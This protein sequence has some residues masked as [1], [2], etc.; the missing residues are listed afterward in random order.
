[1]QLIGTFTAVLLLAGSVQG[2]VVINEL[3]ARNDSTLTN[4]AGFY[5]DWVELYNSGVVAINL[6]GYHL[7]DD[8]S[9]V[10]NPFYF[11]ANTILGP[12]GRLVVWCDSSSAPGEFHTG[13]SLNASGEYLGL[14]APTGLVDS[15]TFGVQIADLSIG[16]IPDGPTGVW[17]LNEPTPGS[18][19][20]AKPLGPIIGLRINEW[21]ATNS[22]PS[23]SLASPGRD[24]LEL[25][26]PSTNPVAL[27]SLVFTT[28]LPPRVPTNTARPNLSFIDALGYVQFFCVGYQKAKAG[29]ELDFKL[30]HRTGETNTLYASDRVTV[31]DQIA[32][33]GN[34]SIV[35]YPACDCSGNYWAPDISYGRL[36]DGGSNIV[37]FE[38]NETTPGAGNFKVI[39]NIVVNEVLSH[40]DPPFEDAI[41]LYNTTAE[42]VDLSNWWISNSLND[43]QKFHI[44]TN[45]MIAPGGYLVFYE[46]RGV[47]N[48]PH[49]GFNTSATGH[50]PDFTLNSAHGDN[51]Y[52][53]VADSAGNLSGYRQVQNFGAAH[54]TSFGR[55]ITSLG[56]DFTAMSGTTFGVD[57]PQSREQFRL[58]TGLTNAYPKVGPLVINEIMYHPPDIL[59]GTTHVNDPLNE[60]IEI[61]NIT[62]NVVYL[63]DTNGAYFDSK[64]GIYA[65]GRTNTWK[66]A[67][68]D[69]FTFTFPTNISLAPGESLLLVNFDPAANRTQSN[70]FQARYR[71]RAGTQIFGP[72]IPCLCDGSEELDNS[73]GSVELYKPDTPQPPSHPDFRFVPYIL[74]ERVSYSA[75][76]PW[77]A[78]PDGGG[79]ALHR[80]V[81]ERYG[82]ELT[83]WEAAFPTPGWQTLQIESF[84]RAGNSVVIAF[85]GL[86]GSSYSVQTGSQLYPPT[87]WVQFTNFSP[88]PI[89]SVQYLT[90]AVTISNRFYRLTTP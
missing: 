69:N 33:P 12:F 14:Y 82:N 30:S 78:S 19:N 63:Y 53:F 81:P 84:Q 29:N 34:D 56:V 80:L 86:A 21:A 68:G 35:Y 22:P 36:P 46:Q 41:E 7:T 11:P 25:Y 4:R 75:S 57:S 39:T 26:N 17:T 72:Y 9:N 3:M 76:A 1:M 71:I 16:R 13:F 74:V 61:Y 44:P 32:F 65:D 64:V 60:Y 15:V 37:R 28:T 2:Q 18:T 87:N 59:S 88:Q 73:G 67:I 51:V 58:G 77:P 79:P 55:F 54:G 83:N 43:R 52:L 5:S 38:I 66:L 20:I 70:T 24:W 49:L 89:S 62:T 48:L 23:P 27:A 85:R 45:T 31:I 6:G 40:T 42:P 10:F 8:H 90:N 50:S 47:T